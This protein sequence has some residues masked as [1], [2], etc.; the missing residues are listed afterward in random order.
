MDEK[1]IEKEGCN[2]NKMS[3]SQK[4]WKNP[5]TVTNATQQPTSHYIY[6]HVYIDAQYIYIYIYRWHS[7]QFFYRGGCEEYPSK[8]CK[9][10]EL[11]GTGKMKIVV[12][13]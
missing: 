11:I 9:D 10:D 6:E 3:K 13:F 7:K 8:G 2:Y 5:M 1:Y 4:T 12:V